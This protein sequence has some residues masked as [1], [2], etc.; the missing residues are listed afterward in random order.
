MKRILNIIVAGIFVVAATTG[1]AATKTGKD[2]NW[3]CTTNASTSAVASDVAADDK[4]AKTA[5]AAA[6]AF[7]FAEANC[8]DCT[9]ITCA[10]QD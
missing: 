9:K 8:R 2:S 1:M 5:A 3:I 4:M 10:V 7:S 6:D